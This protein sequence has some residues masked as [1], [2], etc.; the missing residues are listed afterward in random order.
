[1]VVLGHLVASRTFHSLAGMRHV[2]CTDSAEPFSSLES[3]V[4]GIAFDV[5]SKYPD[6]TVVL[7][8]ARPGVAWE[9]LGGCV[10]PFRP[11]SPRLGVL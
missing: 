4:L 5:S 10:A 3:S 1:M 2:F 6:S 11:L 7:V 9:G 8:E